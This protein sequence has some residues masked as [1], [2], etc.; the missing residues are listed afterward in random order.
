[1]ATERVDELVI[2][3]DEDGFHL[4]VW[5]EEGEEYDFLLGIP[6]TLDDE[7]AKTIRPWRDEAASAHRSFVSR[8]ARDLAGT[9]HDDLDEELHEGPQGIAAHL[10]QRSA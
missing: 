3:T 9:D 4:R 6:E 8:R 1:M 2:D 10:S 7:V 5:T